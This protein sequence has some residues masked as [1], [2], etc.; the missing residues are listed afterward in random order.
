MLVLLV[1]SSV[2]LHQRMHVSQAEDSIRKSISRVRYKCM[3]ANATITTAAQHPTC[4]ASSVQ[5]LHADS[6]GRQRPL[7]VRASHV[8]FFAL[9]SSG[10]ALMT[11]RQVLKG[12]AT[13]VRR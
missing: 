4:V 7:Q 10:F 9:C 8:T 3:I 2:L 6:G 11:T 1:P 12:L 13:S 5:S